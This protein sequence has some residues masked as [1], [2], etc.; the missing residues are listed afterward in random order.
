MKLYECMVCGNVLEVLKDSAI[1]PN[2]C[3]RSM[4]LIKPNTNEK[5]LVEKHVP[6]YIKDGDT[7]TIEVGE[8]VHPSTEE[9]HIEWIALETKESLYRKK[10]NALDHPYA[11]FTLQSDDEEIVNIYAYCNIHGLWSIN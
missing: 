9:H 4:S 2:C 1:V 7:V 10:L 6:V 3:S 8:I 5:G 11:V